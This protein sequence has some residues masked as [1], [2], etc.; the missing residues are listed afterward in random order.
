MT[1]GRRALLLVSTAVS[2][3]AA[4][5]AYQRWGPPPRTLLAFHRIGRGEGKRARELDRIEEEQWAVLKNPDP[6]APQRVLAARTPEEWKYFL[7]ENLAAKLWTVQEGITVYDPWTYARPAPFQ[8]FRA[9]WPEHPQHKWTLHTNSLGLR[10]DHEL[11]SPPADLRVLVAGDSHT[12]GVCSNNESFPNVLEARLRES[13]PGRTVEVVNAAAG[14][15][16][17][18]NYFGT[19]LRFRSFKPQVFV[20][21][22]YAGN[23]FSEAVYPF[24]RFRG[25]KPARWDSD[26]YATRN[27]A[28]RVAP[29]AMGQCFNSTYSFAKQPGQYEVALE[30]SLQLCQEMAQVCRERGIE[31]IVCF[32]PSPCDLQWRP[33]HEDIERAQGLLKLSDKELALSRKIGVEFLRGLSSAGIQVIDMT[34]SFE[35]EPSPPYWREDLHMNVVAHQRIAEAL[36]PLVE[37]KLPR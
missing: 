4:S 7:P 2:V 27:L 15:Y 21:A 19:L 10:E 31:M 14:G 6:S 33:A 28:L 25:S 12:H 17:F 3:A 16:T 36:E 22:V 34:A 1:K 9:K 24:H 18:Y 30:A 11:A 5:W 13:H 35:A 37:S 32:I 8:E 23:D 20:V 29:N 26:S